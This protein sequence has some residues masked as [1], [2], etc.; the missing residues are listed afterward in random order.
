MLPRNPFY[1]TTP[2]YYVNDLPHIGHVYTTVVADALARYHRMRGDD[3]RFLTG[4]DEHGINIQRAAERQGIEPIELAHRVVA[5]YHTLWEE[6]DIT[7]DDFIRTTERRHAASVQ[8]LWRTVRERGDLYLGSY[9]GHYCASCEAFY[10]E[11]QLVNGRC[12]VHERPV[13][14]IEE[15]SWFF[16]LSRWQEP[17]L[18]LYRNRPEFILPESRRNEIVSFVSGG[19]KDLSVSRSS[20]RWGI[21]VPDETG[22]V[23]YV[24]FDAL[25]NYISGLGYGT[26]NDALYTLFWKAGSE[27]SGRLGAAASQAEPGAVPGAPRHPLHLVGKDILRFHSVYW[28]AFLMAAGEPVPGSVFAHGWWLADERKMSKTLGN[29]VRPGPILRV[30]GP[31]PFRWFLLREMTFGLDGTYSD[32]ALIERT[33]AD[34]ANT[35]GNLL[36]RVVS[37]VG[38]RPGGILAPV[39]EAGSFEAVAALRAHGRSAHEQIRDAYERCAFSEALEA[40]VGVLAAINK[41]L[42]VHQPW[43]PFE[44]GG[45]DP[46]E[47]GPDGRLPAWAIL[48]EAAA[49]LRMT[50]VWIAPVCPALARGIWSRMGFGGDPG[51]PGILENLRWEDWPAVIPRSQAPLVPRLD[52]Q[53]TRAALDREREKDSSQTS[54]QAH[55]ESNTM[56]APTD[57]PAATPATPAAPPADPGP[58]PIGIDEFRAI[59]LR[60]ARVVSCERVPRAD[61]L[62]RLVVDLGAETRQVVSGIAA[63]YTPEQ[64][65]GRTII[66]VANLKPAVL[67]GVESHGMLLAAESA[68]GIAIATF[69]G[70]EP[71]PGTR[72]K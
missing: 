18:Q 57:P 48:G 11:G 27:K 69:D 31:E 44:S 38:K 47:P 13:E 29:V 23:I 33:N 52:P 59:D 35:L 67:R 19:L 40:A 49:A 50:A 14:W 63:S 62:L 53:E 41:A 28:P 2:I 22:H 37:L 64:L 65:V 5:R 34:L 70:P 30:L 72:V 51:A 16:R 9:S 55:Q 32:D 45:S 42:V 17:L 46:E 15:P 3:V 39:R 24:W 36:S 66:V 26:D 4:T 25:T 71:P 1:I 56:T 12:P 60:V 20:L 21:P 58:Q 61:R 54:T 43:R 10:P 7:Y 68:S 6:L 8:R